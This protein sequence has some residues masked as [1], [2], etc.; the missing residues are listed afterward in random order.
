MKN[1]RI[2]LRHLAGD[3]AAFGHDA[4]DRRDQRFRRRTHKVERGAPVAQALQLEPGFLELHA[5]DGVAGDELL[6]A[7]EPA[8][9]DRDLLIE[10]ALPLAH[11]GGVDRL[12]RWGHIGQHVALLDRRSEAR[13][14][15]RRRCQAAADRRLHIAAGIGVGDDLAGQLERTTEDAG[16]GDER[17]QRKDPLGILGN[18]QRA[19]RQPLRAIRGRGCGRRCAVILPFMGDTCTGE[20]G[21]GQTQQQGS[22]RAPATGERHQADAGG[23]GRRRGDDDEERLRGAIAEEG[24]QPPAPRFRPAACRNGEESRA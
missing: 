12:H 15:A 19:V 16:P 14:A 9:H 1:D 11:V 22:A 17:A 10:L 20:Q 2:R 23:E 5:R 21:R 13:E 8:L 6:V 18:E 3:G 4:G 7:G 24:A